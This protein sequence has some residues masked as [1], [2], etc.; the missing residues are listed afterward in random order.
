MY[1]MSSSNIL[2]YTAFFALYVICFVYMFRENTGI[3]AVGTLMVVHTA[4]TLFLGNEVTNKLNNPEG[5]NTASTIFTLLSILLA[6]GTHVIALIILMLM[7]L[8]MQKQYNETVGTPINLPSE[9]RQMFDNFKSNALA[10]FIIVCVLIYLISFKRETTN[11]GLTTGIMPIIISVLSTTILGLSIKQIV[12]TAYL[13]KLK[14]RSIA[15][16]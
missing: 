16:M 10:I 6:S 7:L 11:A 13:S 5:A 3:V 8:K 12:N 9:Y 14:N 1:R 15:G 2:N 4:C